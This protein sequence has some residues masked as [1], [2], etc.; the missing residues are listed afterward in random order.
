MVDV[1]GQE[2]RIGFC[3]PSGRHVISY[4]RFGEAVLSHDGFGRKF[5]LGPTNPASSKF[6]L[7]PCSHV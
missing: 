5:A 7:L 1:A 6:S 3:T 4:P 2:L